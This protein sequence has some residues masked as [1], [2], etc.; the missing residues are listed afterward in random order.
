MLGG[1]ARAIALLRLLTSSFSAYGDIKKDLQAS[2]ECQHSRYGSRTATSEH[3]VLLFTS[4]LIKK[5]QQEQRTLL[6]TVVSLALA[7]APPVRAISAVTSREMRHSAI[8]AEILAD[9]NGWTYK[10]HQ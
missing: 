4:M 10:R 9:Q 5:A 8:A 7:A 2:F 3:A 6:V 1:S